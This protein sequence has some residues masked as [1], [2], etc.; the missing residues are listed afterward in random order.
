MKISQLQDGFRYD[1]VCGVIEFP[2][3]G[4]LLL[5]YELWV[6]KELNG[7]CAAADDPNADLRVWMR[8][9]GSNWL[10]TETVGSV[11]QYGG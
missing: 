5:T 7:L 6:I 8:V 4:T 9:K 1:S 10:C 2:N 11:R 3:Y